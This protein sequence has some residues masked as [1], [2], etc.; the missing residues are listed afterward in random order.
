MIVMA[1]LANV[2]MYT[3]TYVYNFIFQYCYCRCRDSYTGIDCSMCENAYYQADGKCVPCN[4]HADGSHS[5][6]CN[7]TT[8]K[9]ACKVCK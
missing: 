3:Y 9:C 2:G 1:P 5:L 8:G 4:C 7:S 6:N